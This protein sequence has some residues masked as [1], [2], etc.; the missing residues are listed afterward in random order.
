M[1]CLLVQPLLGLL[2]HEKFKHV[3][4]RQIWS[5][6]HLFNGRIAITLGIVNGALGLWMAKASDKL[7]VVYV[8][9]AATVWVI[10]VLTAS[11]GEWHRWKRGRD[12]RKTREG[13]TAF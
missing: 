3:G 8:A 6:L 13:Q 2:H 5:Y 12:A 11:W 4:K 7:K 1:V 10:W 9:A